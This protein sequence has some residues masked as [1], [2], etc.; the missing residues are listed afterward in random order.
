MEFTIHPHA[1]SRQV[2]VD[3]NNQDLGYFYQT[4]TDS[5]VYDYDAREKT[6]E[7]VKFARFLDGEI[8]RWNND[9]IESSTSTT[10]VY[11]E[12]NA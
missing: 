1:A 8:E 5:E 10:I 7:Q 3:A 9:S 6:A 4:D 11:N 12:G 2:D